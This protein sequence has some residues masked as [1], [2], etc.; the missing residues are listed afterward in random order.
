MQTPRSAY[1]FSS[2]LL[3]SSVGFLFSKT[4][5]F[6]SWPSEKHFDKY[7]RLCQVITMLNIIKLHA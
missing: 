2:E 5:I 3:L 4:K 7:I 6:F 1:L